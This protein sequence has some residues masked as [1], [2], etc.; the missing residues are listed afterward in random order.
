TSSVRNA[1]VNAFKPYGVKATVDVTHTR[2]SAT[3]SIG[4]AQKMFGTKGDLYASTEQGQE[5]ALPV[6]TPQV[7]SVLNGNVNVISGMALDVE[8]NSAGTAAVRAPQAP[9][10]AIDGGTPTRTGTPDF[11]CA[12][13]TFPSAVSSTAGLYPN[14]ILTAYGIAHLHSDGLEGQG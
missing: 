1:V 11:G 4:N 7:P 2:V 10:D 9:R 3:I 8:Q 13:T 12:T 5:V 6:D 14:Q